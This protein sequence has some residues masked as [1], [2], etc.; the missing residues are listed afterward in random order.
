MPCRVAV[1]LALGKAICD[2]YGGGMTRTDG[3]SDADAELRDAIRSID[4]IGEGASGHED[5]TEAAERKRAEQADK[6]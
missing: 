1:A 6:E 3:T 4:A 2:A 5:P